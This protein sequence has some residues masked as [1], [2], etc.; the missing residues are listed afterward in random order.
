MLLPSQGKPGVRPS[1]NLTSLETRSKSLT[2][3]QYTK[4]KVCCWLRHTW[5]WILVN[6]SSQTLQESLWMGRIVLQEAALLTE[7]RWSRSPG[8]N[9]EEFVCMVISA[10]I[11]LA[12]CLNY[13]S[14]WTMVTKWIRKPTLI[15]WR[16][17]SHLGSWDYR[18]WRVS[19][20]F[21]FSTRLRVTFP[22]YLS[23]G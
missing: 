10:A 13:L 20:C 4:K 16:R 12:T 22:N 18:W 5:K 15:L 8:D 14:K 21:S 3:Q 1:W 2:K 19:I 6:L 17:F 11:V 23:F 7:V 9:K